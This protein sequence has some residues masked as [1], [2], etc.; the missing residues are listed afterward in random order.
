[1]G[2][3]NVRAG[4]TGPQ[5]KSSG[6]NREEPNF[7]VLSLAIKPI[8]VIINL[9]IEFRN[10]Q[11]LSGNPRREIFNGKMIGDQRVKTLW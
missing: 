3:A 7:F 5:K 4:F 8:Y 1:M 9:R 11:I 10:P 6:C 2:L